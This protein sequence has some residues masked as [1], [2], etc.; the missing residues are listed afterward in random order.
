MA[1]PTF[2]FHLT[3]NH[4]FVQ[5]FMDYL[6]TIFLGILA[7]ALNLQSHESGL[8]STDFLLS[9]LIFHVLWSSIFKIHSPAFSNVSCQAIVT[10]SSSLNGLNN[11]VPFLACPALFN[12]AL[13]I[14]LVTRK[15]N[16]ADLEKNKYCLASHVYTL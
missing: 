15:E 7:R 11:L 13:V 9:N 1:F 5:N 12:L 3:V 14:S 10:R 6:S 8:M 16:E 4:H 2:P